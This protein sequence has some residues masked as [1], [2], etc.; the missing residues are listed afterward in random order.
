MRPYLQRL[1]QTYWSHYGTNITDFTF[2]FPNRRAGLFFQKHLA[3][4]ASKPIFAPE[5]MTVNQCFEMLSDLRPADNLTQLFM[6]YDVYETITRRGESFDE[7]VFWGNMLLADFNEVDKNRV[8]AQQLFTNVRDLKSIDLSFD[9]LTE[10]QMKAMEQF[11]GLFHSGEKKENSEKFLE[12]W[13]KL[14][15]I[16]Q[17]FRREL[18]AEG[19]AYEGLLQRQAI[20]NLSNP[21]KA[22]A[23]AN[24][25]F[26]FVGFN[27]LNPCEEALFLHLQKNHQAD[28]CF[29]YESPLVCDPE[30]KA[31]LFVKRNQKQFP[32][33]HTIEPDTQSDLQAR[34]K[35]EQIQLVGIPS[36][37]G[38]TT[39][40]TTLLQ[41]IVKP[42][43]DLTETAIVLP[44]EN[45]LLPLLTAI[46]SEV[47]TVN[48]TMGYPLTSTPIYGLVEH[49][50]ELQKKI[51]RNK[52]GE[53][54]FYHKNVLSI[55]EHQYINNAATEAV[56]STTNRIVRE[57]RI[58][59]P[60]S[61]LEDVD[62]FKAIFK[63]A[64]QSTQAL[65][66]IQTVLEELQQH[67]DESSIDTHHIEQY[68]V[69]IKRLKDIVSTRAQHLH[70]EKETY[71]RLL[72]E[73]TASINIPFVGEPLNG[74]QIMGTLETRCLDFKNLII[75]SM[76]EGV[77]PKKPSNQSFIP[78]NLRRAFGL[79]TYE[80]QD[81]VFSYN[82]YRLIH[83]AERMYFVYDTRTDNNNTGE[84]SRFIQQMNFQ[85]GIQI[86]Q[87]SLAFEL[88]GNNQSK[89]IEVTKDQYVQQQLARYSLRE[90]GRKSISP[91]ALNTYLDCPLKFYFNYVANIQELKGVEETI[92]SSMFGSIFHK[93]MENTYKAFEGKVIEKDMLGTL[94]A[95]DNVIERNI[96]VAYTSEYLR[97]DNREVE[98]QGND[99]LITT[100][101]HK[102]IRKLI[103]ED[104]KR[105]PFTYVKAEE[106]VEMQLPIFEGQRHINLKGFID[107][108]DFKDGALRIIDYKTGQNK[109]V[110]SGL[111]S[112]VDTQT[113]DR[114]EHVLQTLFYTFVY[115]QCR[116]PL[117]QRLQTTRIEPGVIYIRDLFSNEP[118]TCLTDKS[119][120]T[121]DRRV[122]DYTQYEETF[123]QL[124]ISLL[125]EIM[126]TTTPFA[127]CDNPKP[128]EYCPFHEICNR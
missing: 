41:E 22:T 45:L 61:L 87:S 52:E 23:L 89:R 71:F 1:A 12:S 34:G 24:K 79:A 116:Q 33:R 27:A 76:N 58:Y 50:F 119:R 30:N 57:N 39:Y 72:H 51:R 84:V 74:L 110:F 13:E 56:R 4:L 94:L 120:Q 98:P 70:L 38:Q 68:Y 117:I 112:I 78:Y 5:C 2:V 11:W 44:N 67:T 73:L 32:S 6:L 47:D 85:H 31:S 75:L 49:L 105:A 35:A 106:E 95:N 65:S 14:L 48:I 55:L 10:E 29:N 121:D 77:F 28:F 99:K 42:G 92:E 81:A 115:T 53:I 104:I 37:V 46:P 118:N 109:S 64:G 103:R 40:V 107:R 127:Q 20:D 17:Q 80:Q 88:E 69:T 60:Q 126:D 15:P 122:T 101:I 108:V 18:L 93:A 125:E 3:K 63:P 54:L 90:A 124:L 102:Y 123:K 83:Q 19:I 91:S 8:N 97:I 26:V 100:V 111:D 62:L 59:V 82:F 66:Y 16:Y 25:Q 43:V 114:P 86:K 9:Y 21:E 128:C 113:K 96:R 7:F 36:D